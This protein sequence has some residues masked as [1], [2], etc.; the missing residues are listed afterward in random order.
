MRWVRASTE[1]ERELMSL[2][3]N[4]TLHSNRIRLITCSNIDKMDSLVKM[5]KGRQKNEIPMVGW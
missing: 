4:T 1:R 5:E 3:C 2:D